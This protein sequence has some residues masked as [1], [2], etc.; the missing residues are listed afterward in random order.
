MP[1]MSFLKIPSFSAQIIQNASS[2]QPM[3]VWRDLSL[4]DTVALRDSVEDYWTTEKTI[5]TGG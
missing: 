4:L 2:G 3:A 1:N 5:I